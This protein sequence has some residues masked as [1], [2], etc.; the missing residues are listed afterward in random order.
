MPARALSVVK[1]GYEIYTP[2]ANCVD[3]HGMRGDE[4]KMN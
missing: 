1:S 4:S 2:P 3:A